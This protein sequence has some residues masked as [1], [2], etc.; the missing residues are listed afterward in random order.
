M[1]NGCSHHIINTKT[2]YLDVCWDV[3]LLGR[4]TLLVHILQK[5]SM[6]RWEGLCLDRAF[7]SGVDLFK[8]YLTH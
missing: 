3:E 5:Y 8:S 1:T 6:S 2:E 7:L 4:S